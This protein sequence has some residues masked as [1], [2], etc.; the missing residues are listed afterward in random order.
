MQCLS[1]FAPNIR[2]V[3]EVLDS[4][5]IARCSNSAGRN[6]DMINGTLQCL[7]GLLFRLLD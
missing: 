4:R 1:Q 6:C 3:A 2:W 5:A 7:T